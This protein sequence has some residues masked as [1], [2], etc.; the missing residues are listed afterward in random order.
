MTIRQEPPSRLAKTTPGGPASGT[1]CP[2][3]RVV[4]AGRAAS[5][6]LPSLR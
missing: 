2:W 4:P 3:R 6:L 5:A 1:A